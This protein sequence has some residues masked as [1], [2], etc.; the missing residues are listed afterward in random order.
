MSLAEF[1]STEPWLVQGTWFLLQAESTRV[2]SPVP[3]FAVASTCPVI[4][5][6]CLFLLLKT[7]VF[8]L[9]Q[10]GYVANPRSLWENYPHVYLP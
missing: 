4:P 1:W 10:E 9:F 3:C 8:S 7:R 6:H 2:Y 5:T